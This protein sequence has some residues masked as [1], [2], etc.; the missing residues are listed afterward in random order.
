VGN[1]EERAAKG[2]VFPVNSSVFGPLAFE[3]EWNGSLQIHAL[4]GPYIE[5]VQLG[6]TREQIS[7]TLGQ[8]A[9]VNGV[10]VNMSNWPTLPTAA[11]ADPAPEVLIGTITLLP[12]GVF[13]EY[14]TSPGETIADAFDRMLRDPD[15]QPQLAMQCAR[16]PIAI[17]PDGMIAAKELD[18]FSA[19]QGNS[20][21]KL[22]RMRCANSLA[23]FCSA[24]TILAHRGKITGTCRMVTSTGWTSRAGHREPLP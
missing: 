13:A 22:M 6:G 10:A 18:S 15:M 14:E 4:E 8:Y 7:A 12:I 23:Q 1:A 3:A 20:P 11:S 2:G 9:R 16:N 19:M 24:L 21:S 5:A 17:Y